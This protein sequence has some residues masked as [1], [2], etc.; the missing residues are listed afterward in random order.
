MAVYIWDASNYDWQRDADHSINFVAA[1][2]D[3][4]A[5][6][7]HKATEGHTY[8]DPHFGDFARLV[9]AGVG[10]ALVGP[11]HVLWPGD[12]KADA[13]HWFDTVDRLMPWWRDYPGVVN[14]QI[15]AEK[16]A[17]MP[18][19]PNLSEIH[20]CADRIMQRGGSDLPAAAIVV[21]GPKWL[22]GD[23]LRGLRF[24]LWA[25]AYGANPAVRYRQAYPGDNASIWAPYSGV[26][27][28]LAQYGSRT[29]I[30]EQSTCDASAVRVPSEAALQA[31]FGGTDM[32]LDDQ[33]KAWLLAN[34]ATKPQISALKG[35]LFD[36]LATQDQV[37]ALAVQS[38]ARD[39]ALADA[40]GD[41]SGPVDVDQLADALVGRLGPDLGNQLALKLGAAITKGATQ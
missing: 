37:H 26:T 24:K 8:T 33:D 14:W 19:Q 9:N 29:I 38:A 25:S 21:Y 11:Y 2:R 28:T 6:V 30:G 39:T 31:L 15:D 16:F 10:F 12:P 32:A 22:Y 18:R 40:L 35:Q 7:Q 27:P 23:S 4:I 34:L 1:R 17:N 20:A 13:D 36:G 5:G 3:G 41:G